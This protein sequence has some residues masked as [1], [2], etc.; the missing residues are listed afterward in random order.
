APGPAE[1]HPAVRRLKRCILACGVRRNYGKLLAGCRSVKQR[2]GVLR[3]ELE[4]IGLQGG[5]PLWSGAGRC[6]CTG[7]GAAELAALDV[8]NIIVSDEAAPGAATSGVCT[9][10]PPAVPPA[11][12]PDADGGPPI[13]VPH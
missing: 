1:E 3:R 6:G 8:G 13:P 2:V 7:G 10:P 12:P 5:T 4:A 11:A 9:A